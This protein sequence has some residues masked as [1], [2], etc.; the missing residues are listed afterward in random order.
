MRLIKYKNIDDYN[1]YFEFENKDSGE[2]NIESLIGKY[3]TKNELSTV[4]LN[5][6]WGCLEFKKGLVDI[7]PQ[8]LYKFF[9]L[10]TKRKV[11]CDFSPRSHFP[12]GNAYENYNFK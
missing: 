9:N 8:T 2:V 7:E 3:V 6:E 12:S 1:F 4:N 10:R 5:E 11:E